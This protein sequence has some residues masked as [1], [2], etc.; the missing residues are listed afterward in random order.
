MVI[1]VKPLELQG[2]H[3]DSE[4]S[5]ASGLSDF[6]GKEHLEHKKGIQIWEK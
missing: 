2:K 4:D 1:F 5:E 3:V 6:G